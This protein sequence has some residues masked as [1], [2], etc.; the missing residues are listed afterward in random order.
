[1]IAGVGTDIVSVARIRGIVQ[2]YGDKLARRILSAEEFADYQSIE[3]T[4]SFLAKR[5][6]A[7]EAAAKALGTGFQ[8]GVAKR[9]IA[10]RHD[11]L[12]RPLLEFNGGAKLVSNRKGITQAWLSLADER[13]FAV[14]F[15]V[16]ED[17]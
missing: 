17:G 9:D 5:F 12:G 10:V 1:M 7:K 2:R 6:A 14:A 15:V 13:E 3:N 11:E 4:A 16:L 8:L